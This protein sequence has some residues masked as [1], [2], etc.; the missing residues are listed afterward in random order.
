MF[1]MSKIVQ[2]LVILAAIGGFLTFQAESL[3][4]PVSLGAAGPQ[5]FTVLEIGTGEV[6]GVNAGGPKN[7]INGNVGINTNGTLALTGGTFVTGNVFKGTG[8]SVTLSGGA[9][10]GSESFDQALL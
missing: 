7:G 4:L 9:T 2:K 1:A 10:V 5:N 8:A 6:I 3:A